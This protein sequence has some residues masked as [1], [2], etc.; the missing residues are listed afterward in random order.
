MPRLTGKRRVG[1][2]LVAAAAAAAMVITPASAKPNTVAQAPAP[3]DAATTEGADAAGLGGRPGCVSLTNLTERTVEFRDVGPTHAPNDVL[4]SGG[5]YYD[6]I[7]DASGRQIGEAIGLYTVTLVTADGAIYA[8]YLESVEVPQGTY[9]ASGTI[10]RNTARSGAW[11][12]FHAVG[13]GGKLL[14]KQGIRQ[15]RVTDLPSNTAA[16]ET[17]LC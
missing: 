4:G 17:F 6:I 15:W 13:T 1:T 16:L 8:D 9:R 12:K 3:A 10:E 5:M 11:V 7:T 14:G 2:A